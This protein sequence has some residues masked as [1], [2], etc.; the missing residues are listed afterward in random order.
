MTP[1]VAGFRRVYRW[2][3]LTL[4]HHG[5]W[6]LLVL[7]AGAPDVAPEATPLAWCPLRV[8]GPALAAV[9]ALS[10][11]A[12]RPAPA[13]PGEETGPAAS[14]PGSERAALRAQA[15]VALLALPLMLAVGRLVAGPTAPAAKLLGFG[16]ADVAAFH[17]IHFGVVARSFPSVAEGQGAAVLLFGASW[18]LRG[19]LAA[20]LDEVS[21]SDVALAAAGGF[22]LGLAVAGLARALRR[23]PGGFWPAAAAHWLLVYAVFG[24]A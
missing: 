1:S 24:F 2:L 8:A 5:V 4:V 21:A 17:L 15:R 14:A 22:A 13:R 12:Q 16:L 10:Y 11:L 20:G 18:A 9:L 23:W 19:A 3:N 7:V 6:P